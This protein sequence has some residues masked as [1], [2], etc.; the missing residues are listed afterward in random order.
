M[1]YARM[2][3]EEKAQ[4]ESALI[5][6]LEERR[7]AKKRKHESEYYGKWESGELE[8]EENPDVFVKDNSEEGSSGFKSDAEE[9][10]WETCS[11]DV[12]R[13]ELR[14]NSALKSLKE[15]YGNEFW[16]GIKAIEKWGTHTFDEG[17]ENSEI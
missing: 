5:A 13:D 8:E 6:E 12:D 10:G 7:A 1:E 17:D 3:G 15:D 4:A 14:N 9:E 16:K 11:D 2:S